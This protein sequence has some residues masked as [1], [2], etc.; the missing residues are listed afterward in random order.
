MNWEAIG[1]IGEIVGAI[2]VLISLIFIGLQVRQSAAQTAKS[3]LLARAD[4]TE[5]AMRAFGDTAIELSRSR[6]LSAAFRKVMFKSTDLAEDEQTVVFAFF[7]VWLQRHRSAFMSV[8]E[9]LID[10]RVMTDYDN[11]TRWYLTAP[12]FRDEF[13]RNQNNSI[14]SGEFSDHIQSLIN[15][16]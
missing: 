8:P 2:A 7:N 10:E 14:F 11:T 6:E 13:K 9:N 5:R 16:E 12:A 3:N 15:D 1:A 4:M